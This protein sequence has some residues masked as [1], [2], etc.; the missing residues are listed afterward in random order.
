[1]NQVPDGIPA[2]N[3]R[4]VLVR[5]IAVLQVKLI[6]DGFRDLVLVPASLAA[7]IISLLSTENDKPGSHFYRL[8]G[9]GKQTERWI[10]LF[11]ALRN[12][13]ADIDD[14]PTFPDANMDDL[15][16]RLESYVVEEH[17]RG[18]ITSQAKARL[19]RALE[20]INRRGRKA[21]P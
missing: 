15:V 13:P 16:G 4:L 17:K 5:D 6:V 8:L 9:V 20:A 19:D 11:G 14:P 2:Q 1:M 3:A 18:G 12:A 7:G 10:D 21:D